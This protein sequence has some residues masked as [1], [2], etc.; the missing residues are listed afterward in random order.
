[1]TTKLYYENAYQT[2]FEATVLSCEETKKGYEIV[3]DNTAF[4]PE[5]G[6]Q[7]SDFGSLNEVKVLHV[8]EKEGIISHICEAPIDKGSIV[9]GKVDWDRRFRFMQ[10]HSGEHILSGIV[11][12][13]FG[14]DN[15]GFHM[16]KGLVTVD[17]N[18]KFTE[19]ELEWI[20]KQAN[21][22]VFSNIEVKNLF[23]AKEELLAMDYRSKKEIEGNVRIVKIQ[24]I[25]CC[26]CCG[27][28]VRRTGEVGTIVISSAESYKGGTRL[29]LLI[30][31]TA[32]E[33]YKL[34]QK[35][36]KQIVKL[37]SA[38]ADEIVAAVEKQQETLLECKMKQVQLRQ[39]LF[40]LKAEK[41][42]DFPEYQIVIEENLSADEIRQFCDLLMQK[43][44]IAVVFSEQEKD[45]YKYVIGSQTI[46]VTPFSKKINEHF[47]G[48]G[49]GKKEMVQ[50]SVV[51]GKEDLIKFANDICAV[52]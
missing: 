15:V 9:Q 51:G 37:M 13:Q 29:T 41:I 19:E 31:W 49:G 28:H 47:H 38:N 20:E 16:G 4:Y 25:D 34:R 40:Q 39:E 52:Q 5:G 21:Q 6:G 11:K 12:K 24:D 14:Y 30:G 44:K 48:R 1:M 33:D 17:F 27:T 45:A 2:Q 46:D 50:G 32:L 3:V 8:S 36:V 18:G 35:S 43:T 42:Q 10:Q 23:P 7:P 26:A 22:S